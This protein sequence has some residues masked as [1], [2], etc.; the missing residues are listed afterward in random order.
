MTFNP[1]IGF[2]PTLETLDLV[3]GPDGIWYHPTQTISPSARDINVELNVPVVISH[4]TQIPQ[5][6]S[7]PS[8]TSLEDGFQVP[9]DEVTTITE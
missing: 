5:G 3:E 4:D 1:Q 7:L 9:Q 8:S 6:S 2:D